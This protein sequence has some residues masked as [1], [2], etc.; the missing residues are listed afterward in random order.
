MGTAALCER[1]KSWVDYKIEWK[2]T[3]GSEENGAKNMWTN[4]MKL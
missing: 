3:N 2:N 4:L 1:C